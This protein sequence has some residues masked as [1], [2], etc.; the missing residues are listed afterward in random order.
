MRRLQEIGGDDRIL[1]PQQPVVLAV[2]LLH[3][4]LE[5]SRFLVGV[6]QQDD[7]RDGDRL[8]VDVRTSDRS[9][10]EG[11]NQSPGAQVKETH[12]FGFSFRRIFRCDVLDSVVSEMI[13]W[14]DRSHRQ[15]KR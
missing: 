3:P 13:H 8:I 4:E 12:F 2:L 10:T 7:R 9:H 14:S 1:L 5:V 6:S 11:R 15:R